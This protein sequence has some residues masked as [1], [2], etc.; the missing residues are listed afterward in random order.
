MT[1]STPRRPFA[2]ISTRLVV[3]LLIAVLACVLVTV[4]LQPAVTT[5][6]ETNATPTP[7]LT[8]SAGN[9]LKGGQ[10]ISTTPTAIPSPVGTTQVPDVD[11]SPQPT[12]MVTLQSSKST[13]TPPPSQDRMEAQIS[14][15]AGSVSFTVPARPAWWVNTGIHLEVGEAITIVATGAWSPGPPVVG[16]VGPDGSDILWGDNFLNLQDIGS[17]N[18]CASNAMPHWA[19]LIGYIGAAMPPGPELYLRLGA[20]RGDSD[21]LRGQQIFGE[22]DVIGDLMAQLQRRCL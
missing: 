21:F 8:L 2:T 3:T 14:T 5:A 17:C 7:T 18:I 20:T 19:A 9:D 12:P 16:L 13:P 10:T 11:K 1:S 6:Q 4:V 15:S 22:H